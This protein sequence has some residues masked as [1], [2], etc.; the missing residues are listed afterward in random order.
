[1]WSN[2]LERYG[3]EPKNYE[4]MYDMSTASMFFINFMTK[5]FFDK[6]A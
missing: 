6:S 2:N 1:M 5:I 4:S 3:N